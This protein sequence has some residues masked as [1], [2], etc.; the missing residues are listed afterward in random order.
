MDEILF[1][2]DENKNRLNLQKHGVSFEEAVTVFNDDDALIFDDPDHSFG[3]ERFL[4]LGM[5]YSTKICIVS[6]CYRE[7]ERIRLIS[8]RLATKNEKNTYYREI[9]GNLK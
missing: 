3:E 2:W 9:G 8:A 6:H 5:T 1:E 7:Q 4:I